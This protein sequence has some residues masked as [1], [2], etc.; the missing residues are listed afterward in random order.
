MIEGYIFTSRVA[1][2]RILVAK[3]RKSI[4]RVG[5]EFHD[6]S[7]QD[8]QFIPLTEYDQYREGAL[9]M[10]EIIGACVDEK[11]QVK[12]P[13]LAE[14][15]WRYFKHFSEIG[16]KTIYSFIFRKYKSNRRLSFCKDLNI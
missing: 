7:E 6:F 1:L 9:E 15:K 8:F 14:N 12:I 11:S 2:I 13:I 5:S 4:K 3:S 10:L 16:R